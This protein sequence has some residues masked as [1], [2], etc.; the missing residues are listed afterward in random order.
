ML[1]SALLGSQASS[2][3][4]HTPSGSRGSLASPKRSAKTLR[5]I[6]GNVGVEHHRHPI[7]CRDKL[8]ARPAF[9]RLSKNLGMQATCSTYAHEG[10]RGRDQMPSDR[11]LH[12][13]PKATSTITRSRQA[14][15]AATI[16]TSA[17][18]PGFTCRTHLEAYVAGG[19]STRALCALPLLSTL[20]VTQIDGV[21]FSVPCA[22]R[23]DMHRPASAPQWVP[24]VSVV[25]SH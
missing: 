10:P 13:V 15:T 23:Q 3:A 12:F 11:E 5:H 17:G 2:S 19:Y 14:S 6:V 18:R 7:P 4:R 21:G 24:I 1:L 20:P 9:P 25:R 22:R 8:E 16:M